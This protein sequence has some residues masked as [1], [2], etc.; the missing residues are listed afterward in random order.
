MPL[1]PSK[2]GYPPDGLTE[3][4]MGNMPDGAFETPPQLFPRDKGPLWRS[5]ITRTVLD[6]GPMA[7]MAWCSQTFKK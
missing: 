3:M 7:A 1:L 6:S 4:L 2:S 5:P